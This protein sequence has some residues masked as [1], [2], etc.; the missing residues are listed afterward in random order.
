MKDADF[1]KRL[2]QLRVEAGLTQN[3]LEISCDMPL[4]VISQYEI[5]T[6]QPGLQAIKKLCK[7]LECTASE[8]IGI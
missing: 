1:C 4:S 7:G 8:L 5:G 3:E 6:R 2:C